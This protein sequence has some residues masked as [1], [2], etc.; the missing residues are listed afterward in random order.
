MKEE[1]NVIV[2]VNTVLGEGEAAR[3][4]SNIYRFN[5]DDIDKFLFD[6]ESNCVYRQHLIPEEDTRISPIKKRVAQL[7]GA[8]APHE[9]V[10]IMSVANTLFNERLVKDMHQAYIYVNNYL[11]SHAEFKK[12]GTPGGPS[13]IAPNKD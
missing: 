12:I 3:P 7:L 1:C 13:Y 8:L 6:C 4:V 9:A 11:K 2:I 5:V 10:T